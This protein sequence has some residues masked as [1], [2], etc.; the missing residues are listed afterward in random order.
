M[1]HGFAPFK[2][3]A[4]SEVQDSMLKGSYDINQKLSTNVKNLISQILQ[5]NGDLRLSL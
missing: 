1:L 4:I 3:K 5:F 2:G